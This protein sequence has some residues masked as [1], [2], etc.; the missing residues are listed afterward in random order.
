ML[1][2]RLLIA[3]LQQGLPLHPRPYQQLAEQIGSSE[4]EVLDY[5]KHMN[6]QGSIK[7]FGLVVRH[8]KLGYKANAM[9]VWDIADEQVDE[10]GRCFG[11][12][13][14]VTLSYRRPRHLPDWPYNLFCMIH[15]QDREDVLANLAFMIERCQVQDIRHEAL[16]SKRCFKQRG[17]YYIHAQTREAV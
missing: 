13:E 6:Q 7:R 3:A 12:F 9:V 1:D 2:E 8:R 16:F 4:A 17:A 5:I 14:F 15:G 10:L 11:Q